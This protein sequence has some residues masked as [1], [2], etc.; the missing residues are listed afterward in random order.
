MPQLRRKDLATKMCSLTGA[1][2]PSGCF[3]AT[4][5]KNPKKLKFSY[6]C[7]ELGQ[8]WYNDLRNDEAKTFGL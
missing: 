1:G 7:A 5:S 8:R 2:I 4:A 3:S 6:G